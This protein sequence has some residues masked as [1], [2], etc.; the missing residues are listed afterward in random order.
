MLALTAITTQL[1]RDNGKAVGCAPD[2]DHWLFANCGSR[3]CIN[4]LHVFT[5]MQCAAMARSVFVK[6]VK[7]VNMQANFSRIQTS[8]IKDTSINNNQ[9]DGDYVQVGNAHRR[10]QL[11]TNSNS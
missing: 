8:I 9:N 1:F 7:K 4:F 6:T 2:G 10:G 11:F 5:T 3:L